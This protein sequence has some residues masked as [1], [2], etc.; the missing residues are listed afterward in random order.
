MNKRKIAETLLLVQGIVEAA[1]VELVET[2]LTLSIKKDSLFDSVELANRV[3][4]G[5]EIMD[6][7]H[8]AIGSLI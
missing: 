6:R 7:V 8:E 2:T 4:T 3:I 1:D 5:E